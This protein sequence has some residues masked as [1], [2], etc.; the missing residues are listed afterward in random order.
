MFEQRPTGRKWKYTGKGGLEV[1]PKYEGRTR[2]QDSL[3]T[4]I[5]YFERKAERAKE[6]K[7][8]M[9]RNGQK[10]ITDFI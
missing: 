1:N 2:E 5:R 10:R 7:E 8:R 4:S 3:Q 6:E 9:F